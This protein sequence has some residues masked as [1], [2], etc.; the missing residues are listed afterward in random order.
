[1]LTGDARAA[2]VLANSFS[3]LVPGYATPKR[4]NDDI[5]WC[6]H[7]WLQAFKL[8]GNATYLEEVVAIYNE[9]FDPKSPW[10]GW[11]ATCGGM[12]WW[13]T[14]FYVNSI[15]N[16][17]AFTG[18]VS[19]QRVTGSTAPLQGRPMLEWAQ[20]IW[21]WAQRPGLISADGVFLDGF[22]ADCVTPTGSAWTYNSGIWLDGLT[23]LAL[24]TG[25]ASFSD[26]AFTLA[27]AAASHFSG[28]NADGIMRELSCGNAQGACGGADGREF[29]GVFARHLSY[30][31]ADWA[32]P[33]SSASNAAAAAWA[34]AWI[35]KHSA[36]IVSLDA[37]VL[38][39]G[40]TPLFGQLW[41]G[42]Y[43]ADNTPWISHS[44]AWDVVLAELRSA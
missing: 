39:P 42:P 40:G 3:V 18:L 33:G 29:K 13:S 35:L 19:L 31:L 41:Q 38:S 11:N 14:D 9:L 7:A 27:Q 24:A 22:A 10:H 8:T 32:A 30:A 26:A 16:G 43:A 36:S 21:Q 15:T 2:G 6:A 1:M 20:L 5:Q 44:A 12:N 37:G 17:L 34:R 25:N 23:G 4:L 28:G